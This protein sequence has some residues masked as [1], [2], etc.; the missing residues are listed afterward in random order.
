MLAEAGVREVGRDEARA[1]LGFAAPGLAIPYRRRNGDPL[2][3]DGKPFHRLRLSNPSNG[4]KYFSPR[5]SGCQLYHPPRLRSLLAPGCVLGVVEGEFKSMALVDAGFPCVGIGGIN[6]ACPR[7]DADESE[8]LPDL[9]EL[10]AEV[11]PRCLAFIGDSDTALIPA[12]SREAVKLA[13]LTGVPVSLPRIPLDAPGKGA[14]DLREI[15]GGEFSVR[16]KAI[17][18][19]AERITADTKPAALA[20]RLLRRE[21]NAF[22]NLDPDSLE[23]ARG[24]LVKLGAGYQDDALAFEEISTIAASVAG[25]SKQTFRSAV[26][27]EATR[28]AIAANKAREGSALQAFEKDFADNPIFFDGRAY[29]RKERDGSF[30]QLCREDARLH[31]GMLG[32]NQ[33]ASA[34]KPSPVDCA[35]HRIQ[36]ERRVNYAGPVCG[37]PPGLL[38]ENGRR[39]LVTSGPIFIPAKAGNCPT[40]LNLVA[41]LFGRASRDPL[42]QMQTA[43][44]IAWLKLGRLAV[45]NPREHRPGQVLALVGPADCGKSL[46]Q[47][48]VI[49]PAL[50]GRVADPALWTTGGTAFNADLWGAEHLAIGDKGLG[51][52]GRERARLRDE[53]KRMTAASEY[54]LHAKNR[55]ALTLRQIWRVSLSANDDPES[56]SNLPAL[57]ASFA[58]KIIYL[59]CFSPPKPFFNEDEPG[60]RARFAKALADELPAFLAYVESFEIPADLRKERFGVREFHHSRVLDLIKRSSPLVPVGEA[61]EGWIATWESGTAEVE[62]P[63]VELYAKLDQHFDGRL[64]AISSGPKHLG[65]Q[66]ARLAMLEGWSGRIVRHE[67]RIGDRTRNQ[68]QTVWAIRRE[69]VAE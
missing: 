37:R 8:L 48:T 51:E 10:I 44:F 30:G 4:A 1:L 2:E 45:H 26:R 25:L 53:L 42:A 6:S 24:R 55:D 69:P 54:P 49:T 46:L 12:F 65:H 38:V 29:W 43:V 14:D 66:L 50:G 56:A 23:S 11:R 57:D 60:A 52:D 33:F 22:A 40:I 19:T 5:G 35:L 41:N 32:L 3:I 9:A 18:D 13:Q 62:A 7:N 34:G 68:R 27:E 58:D 61:L 21:A 63:S 20:V 16:W 31:L 59:Q 64:R 36:Q 67:R 28:Q 47:S 17:L 39:V 15:L